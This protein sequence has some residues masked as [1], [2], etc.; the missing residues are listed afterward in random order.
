MTL[1]R[2]D[3]SVTPFAH[4]HFLAV[5]PGPRLLSD[6]IISSEVMG[7]DGFGGG[8]SGGMDVEGGGSGG[9]GGGG[10][11]F[12][13]DPDMDPELAMVRLSLQILEIHPYTRD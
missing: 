12:G 2:A 5:Q 9:G 13:V 4:S 10:F 11:E 8:G 3:A 7:L 1:A 6:M